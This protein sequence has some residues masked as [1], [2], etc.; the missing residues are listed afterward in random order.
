MTYRASAL[1][2]SCNSKADGSASTFTGTN[3]ELLLWLVN[4]LVQ[5]ATMVACANLLPVYKNNPMQANAVGASAGARAYLD[6]LCLASTSR[7]KGV[8]PPQGEHGSSQRHVAPVCQG[9]ND[10]APIVAL[11][12]IPIGEY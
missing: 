6:S 7:A 8:A 3:L 10:Q 2:K 5:P 9:C 11:V 12:L 4:G 1:P